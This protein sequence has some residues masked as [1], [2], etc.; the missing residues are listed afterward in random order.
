[1]NEFD[2]ETP[3]D[4]HGTNCIKWDRAGGRFQEKDVLPL[5]IADTDFA[6]PPAV[7][8]AIRSRNEHPIYGYGMTPPEFYANFMNW[9]HDRH[10]VAIKKEWIQVG[11]GVVTAVSYAVQ[12][13]TVPGDRVLIQTP[14]YDP[15][16]AVVN[17]TGRALVCSPLIFK[18]NTYIMDYEALEEEFR[19]GVRLMILCNPHNPVGRVW[20]VEE[21]ER[22]AELCLKYHVYLVSDEIHADFGLFGHS[23]V[24]ALRLPELYPLLVC[25]LA[26]GKTFNISGLAISATVI[27]DKDLHEQISRQLRSAWLI[28]PSLLGLEA[29]AAAYGQGSDWM[30][31]QIRYLEGNSRLVTGRLA[32]DAPH[33]HPAVHEGTF[34]MWLDFSDFSMPD[35]DLSAEIVHTWKLGMNEGWHYGRGGE[36]HMRLNIGCSRILLNEALNR[37]TA[38]H[39]AHFA[40]EG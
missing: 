13:L 28:N 39:R 24:S 1:M 11:T 6:C 22:L 19:S 20:T 29:A 34:M 2:F 5:W 17:G 27:P 35:D 37:L 9:F 25:C 33:I 21:L 8:E 40:V 36:H 26:P 7:Q 10:E 38:M 32:A 23:Y 15:F 3:I 16:A 12:T 14:V 30:D 31:G 18:D 4:R